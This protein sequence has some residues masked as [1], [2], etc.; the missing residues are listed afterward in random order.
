MSHRI[1]AAKQRAFEFR[2][3]GGVRR[4]AGPKRQR[5]RPATPHR[6]RP[7]LRPY[8]PVHATLRFLDHVWNLRSQRSFAIVDRAM[9]G[10]RHRPDF[11]VVHFTVLGNHLHLILEADGSRA[12]ATGM[13]A[14][15]IR[16]ARGLNAMMG[17]KGPVLEDRYDAHVLK[18]RAE[19][20]NAVRYVLGNFASH[21]ARRGERVRAGFVDPFSSAA[22]TTPRRVQMELW[23]EPVTRAAWT[24]LLRRARAWG[25]R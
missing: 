18:T 13:R 22:A 16:T 5:P 24:W 17:R 19:V 20:R 25:I 14:L 8:Q 6:P 3:W 9:A 11:R 2:T 7:A 21:A 23:P 15:S 12:L 10:V 1:A 4:G